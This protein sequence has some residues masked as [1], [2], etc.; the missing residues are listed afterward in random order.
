MPNFS[1]LT[2]HTTFIQSVKAIRQRLK[3]GGILVGCVPDAT[4]ILD[5]LPFRDP[6]GNWMEANGPV[7]FG[8]FGETIRVFLTDTPYYS[9]GP[10]PEP[11]MYRDML[12]T[13]LE[14]KGLLLE[15]WEQFDGEPL[16]R[17]YSKFIYRLY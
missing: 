2:D 7:G 1:V 15:A 4:H 10:H 16:Q 9:Q 14:A 11:M 3:P 17:L 12:T 13:H 6:L 5:S 8:G